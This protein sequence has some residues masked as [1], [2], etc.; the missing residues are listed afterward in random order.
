MALDPG[1]EGAMQGIKG[2]ACHE[3]LGR[4]QLGT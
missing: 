4:L 1:L 3:E 2:H